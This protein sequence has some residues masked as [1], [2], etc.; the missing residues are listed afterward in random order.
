[1]EQLRV[2]TGLRGLD[3]YQQAIPTD[4]SAN[5]L[6]VSNSKRNLRV[7]V[8]TKGVHTTGLRA[9]GQGD[10]IVNEIRIDSAATWSCADP[11]R[12]AR[13]TADA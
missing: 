3:F 12:V 13:G 8:L 10:P 5:A 6:A 11:Y 7:C 9:A 2:S 1:M 4:G